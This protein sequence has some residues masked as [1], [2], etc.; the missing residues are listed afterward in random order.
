[1]LEHL[2]REAGRAQRGLRIAEQ[3]VA[4]GRAQLARTWS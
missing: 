1:L 2:E 3:R 4:E